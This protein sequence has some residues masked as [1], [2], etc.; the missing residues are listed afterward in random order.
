MYN[1][2]LALHS[3]ARWVLLITLVLSI[4][5]AFRGWFAK[6]PFTK[7]SNKL[8]LWTTM[9]AHIQLLLGIVLYFISPVIRYFLDNF[10]VAVKAKA[11]RFFAMEHSVMMLIAVVLIT[12]GS[13]KSK[14]KT[15]DQ[16]KYKTIAI[17]FTIGLVIILLNIPWPFL[18]EISRP[19][20][21]GF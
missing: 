21:R 2:L 20:F 11:T 5:L 9:F 18:A 17:W 1:Y 12:I 6:A 15:T 7:G 10:D 16:A 4:V 13:A 3:V 8:R 14:R 19:Y